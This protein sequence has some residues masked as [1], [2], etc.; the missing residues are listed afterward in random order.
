M[1]VEACTRPGRPRHRDSLI[2][3]LALTAIAH[4]PVGAFEQIQNPAARSQQSL[5]GDWNVIPD[6]YETGFYSHRYQER[7]DGYF[8]NARSRSESDLVEYDFSTSQT[9]VVPGDWNSQDPQLFFYEGTV[10][11]QKDFEL[12]PRLGKRYLLHFG[13]VNYRAIVYVNGRKAG[14]HEGGFTPFQFDVTDL[15]I[16]GGNFVVVKV[17]NRRE[18]DGVPALNTDWWNYGGITRPVRLIEVGSAYLADY[19]VRWVPGQVN[20]IGGWVRVEGEAAAG[21]VILSIPE[22]GIEQAVAVDTDGLGRF[23]VEASP[24]LWSPES[25]K[26]YDVSLAYGGQAVK[27]R[28]GFRHVEARGPDILLNGEPV[29]L[30]GISIHEEA[31]DRPGRAWN[32]ADARATL[33]WAR[34]LG[35]NFVRLAHYPHNEAMV[36]VAD[37]LGLM[38]WSEIPVYWTIDFESEAVYAN[39][40]R[41][42]KEMIARDRNRASVVLWS[43]ANETPDTPA[44][45]DFLSRLITTARGLDDSRLLTAASDTQQHL[46]NVRRIDD[47]LAPLVDVIGINSYCGWYGGTPESCAGLRWESDYGK[48]VVMSEFGAGAKQGLHGRKTQ[49]WTEEYQAEVY[50]SNLLMLDAMPFLRGTTPWIL[51]D[52]RS[53]RRPLPGIQDFWNRKGL[54]SETGQRKLAWSVLRDYY[55]GRAPKAQP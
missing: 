50:R 9:L 38:V 48:P 43:V 7:Q 39:A 46:E 4:D 53:P 45:L 52:F 28:I 54:L 13:A 32:E 44:R 5:D 3:L 15:V 31:P 2:L 34:E 22:L 33:G 30:R 35:C 8:I 42:L 24:E 51:K 27:D 29:W 40:E 6:P 26:L 20:S 55:E 1:S 37:E 12:R 49:R 17:D 23:L 41:Q 10:W 14:S 11:Y 21:P 16:D 47:P 36:R 19:L 25:P 18:R